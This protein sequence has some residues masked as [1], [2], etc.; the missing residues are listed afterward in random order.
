VG[1]SPTVCSIARETYQW[2]SNAKILHIFSLVI[3]VHQNARL[4][5]ESAGPNRRVTCSP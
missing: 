1:L 2:R 4:W 5:F 3:L